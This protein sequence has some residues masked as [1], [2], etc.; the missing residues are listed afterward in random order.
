MVSVKHRRCAVAG[1]PSGLRPAPSRGSLASA[2]PGKCKAPLILCRALDSRGG[3]AYI[4]KRNPIT[5][6]QGGHPSGR[7]HGRQETPLQPNGRP[8][9]TLRKEPFDGYLTLRP[10][11]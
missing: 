9:S 1:L 6:R 11:P 4:Q 7:V 5:T 2:N 10:V 3:D 8:Q